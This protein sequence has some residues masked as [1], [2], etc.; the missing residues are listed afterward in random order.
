MEGYGFRLFTKNSDRI[1]IGTTCT[2]GYLIRKEG[3]QSQ[4]KLS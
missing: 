3:V 1:F 2:D 4:N